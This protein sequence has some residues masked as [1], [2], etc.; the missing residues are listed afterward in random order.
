ME[1][2]RNT[3]EREFVKYSK[4]KWMR[5]GGELESMQRGGDTAGKG[6]EFSHQPAASPSRPSHLA[7]AESVPNYARL[8]YTHIK[9]LFPCVCVCNARPL[10]FLCAKVTHTHIMPAGDEYPAVHPF[11]AIGSVGKITWKWR[12]QLAAR[13]EIVFFSAAGND[14]AAS[15]F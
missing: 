7:A 13:K 1:G 10:A 2:T 4:W 5:R 14:P 8:I 9:S 11:M 15:Q 6:R 12:R 3:G